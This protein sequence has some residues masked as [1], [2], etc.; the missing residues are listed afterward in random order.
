MENKPITLAVAGG[1]KT[2]GVVRIS[3]AA[4]RVVQRLQAK[5]GLNACKIVS[6]IIVQAEGL[7]AVVSE[8][9]EDVDGE[10][11]AEEGV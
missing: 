8:E 9:V 4:Q 7:I 2:T 5:T 11:E 10:E 1:G 6:E 3:P